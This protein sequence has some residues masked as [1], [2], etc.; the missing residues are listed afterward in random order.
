[1]GRHSRSCPLVGTG[2]RAVRS[3]TEVRVADRLNGGL[4]EPALPQCL[5]GMPPNTT[6]RGFNPVRLK[7]VGS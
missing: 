7:M 1:M 4:G 6:N 5:L 2:L 3:Q